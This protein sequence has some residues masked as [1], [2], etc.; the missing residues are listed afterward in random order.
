MPMFLGFHPNLWRTFKVR[1]ESLEAAAR[2]VRPPAPPQPRTWKPK[3]PQ[4]KILP[5]YE[6]TFEESYWADWPSYRPTDWT[7][8]SW[9]SGQELEREAREVGYPLWGSLLWCVDQLEHGAWTGVRGAARLASEGRNAKSAIKHGHLL[10]DSLADWVRLQLIAGPYSP[11]EIPWISIKISPLGIQVKP[12]GA[13]RV[14]VDMSFPWKD[15]KEV[16]IHGTVPISP[17]DGIDLKSF[18]TAMDGTPRILHLMTRWGPGCF[19]TKAGNWFFFMLI[20]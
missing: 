18:P 11:E 14:L 12:S 15:G 7:P 9:I 5:T 20:L 2:D 16:N 8:S 6:G 1:K 13:G 10:S 4:L 3:Q 17:N 19:M